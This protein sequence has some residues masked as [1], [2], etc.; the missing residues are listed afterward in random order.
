MC[1]RSCDEPRLDAGM[2]A[3]LTGLRHMEWAVGRTE[4]CATPARVEPR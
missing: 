3:Y 1:E 2:N 4:C